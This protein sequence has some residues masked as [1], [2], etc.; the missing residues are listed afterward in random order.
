MDA[1]KTM[2]VGARRNDVEKVV[3]RG[4][5]VLAGELVDLRYFAAA[6][7][8]GE[9]KMHQ[10]C[11]ELCPRGGIPAMFMAVEEGKSVPYLLVDA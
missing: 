10:A 3:W 8:P 5:V 7:K 9:G 2:D 4:H 11:A 6:T 1:I